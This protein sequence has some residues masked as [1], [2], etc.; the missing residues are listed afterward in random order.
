MENYRLVSVKIKGFRGFPEQAGEREFR[1]DQACTLIVG[2][3]GGG[4]SSTLN[5]IEWC[6]FGKDVAN[7]SAT[8]IEERKNWLVKNQSSRETSVEVIFEGNE[9]IL[10]VYRSDRKRRGNPK[11]YY[12]INNGSYQEDETDLRVLLGLELSD[13]MSCVY[14]HQET[15]SALLIQEPKERKNALDRLMGLTD[16]RNL[17]DGIK[18]AKAQEEFK[19]I[20]QEFSQIISKIETAKAIKENDLGLAE[21]E[22]IFHDIPLSQLSLNGA[23]AICQGVENAVEN[24]AKDYGLLVPSLPKYQTT[25]DL[26]GFVDGGKEAIK[27]LRNAQPDWER[28]KELLNQQSELNRLKANVETKVMELNQKENEIHQLEAQYGML[29]EILAK[30]NQIEQEE[31][32]AKQGSLNTIN[33]RAGIII[34]TL[35]FLKSVQEDQAQDC[36]VCST[37]INPV[38]LRQELESWQQDMK[39]QLK[40]IQKEIR[41]LETA[42]EELQRL[43]KTL[44]RLQRERLDKDKGLQ[45]AKNAIAVALETEINDS[46]HALAL[47]NQAITDVDQELVRI[48]TAV[49]QSNQR[50]DSID[51]DLENIK[52]IIT[53]LRYRQEVDNLFSIQ[54]CP[55][56]KEVEA[57]KADL[58]AFC[59]RLLTIGEAVQEVLG[60]SAKEKI[61]ATRAAISS[62]YRQ[63]AHR[64][65]FPDIEIDPEKYEVMAVGYGE[66]E[67]ALRLLNK[68]DINCAALSIFLALATSEQLTHN[69]GFM[70]LDDPSQNLD[71]VHKERLAQVLDQVLEKKQLIIA[72]S[73]DDFVEQ[74][75]FKLT[76][77]NKLYRLGQWTPTR[78]PTIE[79]NG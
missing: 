56:Y 67:V 57:A 49:E 74:L 78:G 9:E 76:K 8:K 46:A 3:Q 5:A 63:L 62:I 16:W 36:P 2:A 4:K 31:L 43:I 53:V 75:S 24:F 47:L 79:D 59:D 11:F 26:E 22:A 51:Q 12:Q 15:I 17:L 64:S 69:I 41:E 25:D 44:E 37:P 48:R 30:K 1:F 27:Q 10:K 13:Y 45:Q 52:R 71:P 6:L 21:E 7:K 42:V 54:D 77:P 14:L 19:K 70:V 34:Q 68:G 60:N 39:L 20:D 58:E 38:Q 73:E 66:S 33:N 72:T 32:P 29:P 50:I 23:K 35:K 55:D 61:D 40:P 28:Q 65:D 18:R